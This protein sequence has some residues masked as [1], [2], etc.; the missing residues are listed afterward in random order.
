MPLLIDCY[1]VLHARMPGMLAGLDEVGLCFALGR[2][3]WANERV[4]VVCDGNPKPLGLIESPVDNVELVYSGQGR[5]ADTV[6]IEMI[7]ADTAP[8]RLTVVSSDREI[9]KAARRRR[10]KVLGSDQFIAQLAAS[11]SSGAGAPP[12]AKP[13][14]G[15]LSDDDVNR[16]LERFGF[17]VEQIDDGGDP[18][19]EVWPPKT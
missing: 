2:S 1:N 19:E 18:D 7:G 5:D 4:T 12:T 14:P 6:I 8:K 16:W 3:G 13:S 11:L 17:D 10:A 9:Q 15:K